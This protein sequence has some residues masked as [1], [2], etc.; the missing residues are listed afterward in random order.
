M[1]Q[2]IHIVWFKR[3]LRVNDHA[4]LAYAVAEG[5]S[6]LPLY[7]IEEEY[8][9]QDFASRRHWSFIRDC[10][11]DLREDTAA[12]GQP[13]VVREGEICE[14][15][16]DISSKYIIKGIF[17]HE[18]CGNNWTYQRDKKVIAWCK[19][20]NIP[21]HEFPHNGVVRRLESRDHW[22]KI[23]NARM[24]KPLINSPDNIPVLASESIGEIPSANH[25][26]FGDALV[27]TVQ[28]GGRREA[29]KILDSFLARRSVY[30]VQ[31]ISNPGRSGHYCSRLSGHLTWGSLSVREVVKATKAFAQTSAFGQHGEQKRSF[32]AFNNRL[33]WRCHFMQ[34]LEDQPSIEFECMHSAY[35]GIRKTHP[36]TA[37]YYQAWAEG[38]TGYP[39]IDACMRSLVHRGWITF[40]MRA[41]LVSFASYHLWLDWRQ[42]GYHL[43]R[44]F[45]DYEPGI[46][47]SQLQ[48]QSGVTG[49]NT[50][51]IYNP[52]KQSQDQDPKGQFI[53]QWVP[54]LRNVSDM[55]IHEPWKMSSALQQRASC[56]IGEDYPA[57]IVE[58]AS[59]I[60]AAR[61]GL[62]AA[63]TQ[64][65][66]R[67]EAN[68]IFDKLGSRQRPKKPATSKVDSSQLSLFN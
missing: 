6:V 24:A 2:P 33:A 43:A 61:L 12:L 48:M 5:I 31:N 39:L 4:P 10:L 47:Y 49:I 68:Q 20:N 46:H 53:R 23:R 40:R 57:P 59:A 45:T 64:A 58:H 60:K 36:Q 54:E 16:H 42:T 37:I 3:D 8:W 26:M 19:S 66:Y 13:L 38:R 15:F 44:V 56:L 18:E 1:K 34:K 7:V 55:W 67:Q 32:S 41:M 28:P 29:L 11:L 50:T 52:I 62:S 27:G 21:L 9:Q 17:S 25:P 30:Y 35:E 63:L 65:D 14:I 51:R 22:S